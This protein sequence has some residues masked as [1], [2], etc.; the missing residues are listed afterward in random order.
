M[1]RV[2]VA[3]V[4]G[5]GNVKIVWIILDGSC[6]SQLSFSMLK[7]RFISCALAGMRSHWTRSYKY[8]F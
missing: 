8:E 1:G 6:S 5:G 2:V 7:F 3:D 4:T